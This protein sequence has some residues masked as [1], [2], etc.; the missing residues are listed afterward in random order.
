MQEPKNP[1]FTN[2]ISLT[3]Y[4]VISVVEYLALWSEA[5]INRGRVC[6]LL[7]K[8]NLFPLHL[9]Y[10]IKIFKIL[11]FYYL[12]QSLNYSLNKFKIKSL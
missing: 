4:I 6:A 1:L 9:L 5:L 8:P 2:N 10:Y 11:T 12:I 3:K 7:K